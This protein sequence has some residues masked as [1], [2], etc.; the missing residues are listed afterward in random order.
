MSFSF[1]NG[2]RPRGQSE[3]PFS[4]GNIRIDLWG[5]S[6]AIGRADATDLDTSPLSSDPELADYMDGTLPLSRCFIWTG[7]AYVTLTSATNSATAG[8]FGLEF[9]FAVE[10]MRKTTSGI[11]LFHKEVS[12]GVSITYWDPSEGSSTY[13]GCKSRRTTANSWLVTNGITLSDTHFVFVQGEADRLE[14]EAWYQAQLDEL[15]TAR[16]ADSLDTSTGI[17][18]LAQ[19]KVGSAQQGAGVTSA[20]T[21]IAAADP[22][23]IKTVQMDYYKGDNVHCNGRGQVQLGYDVFA[24]VFSRVPTST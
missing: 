12:S 15:L 20:K 17:K 8:Q 3:A 9:G 16:L 22:T 4:P 11:A 10:W 24:T 1:V 5:Q 7:S 18:V 2:R 21:A 13:N 14:T 23:H 19:M 6:N